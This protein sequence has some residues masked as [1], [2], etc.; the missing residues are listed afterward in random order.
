MTRERYAHS[1][2]FR[3]FIAFLFLIALFMFFS[4][5]FTNR[6]SASSISFNNGSGTTISDITEQIKDGTVMSASSSFGN[7]IRQTANEIY[8]KLGIGEW[9]Q[10]FFDNASDGGGGGKIRF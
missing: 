5:M 7:M 4:F 9:L 3:S 10:K 1:G 2:L 6:V 8:Q